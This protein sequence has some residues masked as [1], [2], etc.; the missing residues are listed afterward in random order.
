M[1]VII[2]NTFDLRLLAQP[3]YCSR[4][5][6]DE[7]T[8]D[9]VRRACR[10]SAHV[11]EM[12]DTDEW[13]RAALGTIVER[14][15]TDRVWEVKDHFMEI[16]DTL[17]VCPKPDGVHWFRVTLLSDAE[18]YAKTVPNLDTEVTAIYELLRD[19]GGP[20]AFIPERLRLRGEYSLHRV[21]KTVLNKTTNNVISDA[22]R[23][24]NDDISR[25][26]VALRMAL[27]RLV[28]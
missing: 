20:V 2:S 24:G 12:D 13:G 11:L 3:G 10:R 21:C 15:N 19:I 9:Q 22:L 14:L 28:A 4:I 7:V 23:Q 16:G 27:D 1:R 18:L 6:M 26:R 5:M 8:F 17:Y 25:M